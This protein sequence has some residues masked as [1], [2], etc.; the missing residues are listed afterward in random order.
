MSYTLK[1]R[2]Q[3]RLAAVLL[4]L[5]VAAA[6]SAALHSWWPVELAAL[7]VAVG[8]ALD[9]AVY[10][11]LLSYQPG[12]AA[13]PLGALEFAATMALVLLL[14]VAAPLAPALALFGLAWLWAQILAH[15]GFPL[16]E[17]SYAED[18]GELRRAGPFAAGAVAAILALTGGV[19]WATRP[20]VVHLHGVV[21]G[22][23]VLDHEQ[24][25]IGGVVRGGIVI[26]A[27]HVTLKHVSTIGGDYGIEVREAD[28][29]RLEDVSVLNARED[30]IHARR[31]GVTVKGCAITAGPATQA[32]DISFAMQKMSDVSGCT[33]TGGL[34]GIVVHFTMAHI[35]DNRVTGTTDRAIAM[36]EMSMGEVTG[37]DVVGAHGT[38]VYCGDYSECHVDRNTIVGPRESILANY[39]ASAHVSRN[40]VDGS[41]RAIVNSELVR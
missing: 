22:P 40:A 21:R 18:G 17:L 11:P 12:W 34:D 31:S 25:V 1:G 15:A 5:A 35:H 14:N 30:G 8:L 29:V 2:I 16:L 3:S 24:T 4:P 9:A 10:H 23:L 37:N 27:D 33:I 38:G 41:V 36:T 32:I 19:A 39:G 20:P 7:M 6:L 26:T 13:L 28:H